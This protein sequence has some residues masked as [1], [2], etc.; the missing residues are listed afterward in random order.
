MAALL[1]DSRWA[2][3]EGQKLEQRFGKEVRA[4]TSEKGSNPQKSEMEDWWA[5]S[6]SHYCVMFCQKTYRRHFFPSSA[7]RDNDCLKFHLPIII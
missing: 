7:L 3:H 1:P 2:K 6:S 5:V 4:Q